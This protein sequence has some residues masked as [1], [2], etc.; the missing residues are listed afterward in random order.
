MRTKGN[1]IYD[2]GKDMVGRVASVEDTYGDEGS[3][4][5]FFYCAKASPSDR[6]KYNNH[7]TVKSTAL[8]EYLIKLVKQP[9]VNLILDPFAGSGSTLVAAEQLGLD[10]VGI[11]MNEEYIEIIKK[12]LGE[13]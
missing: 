4:A 5:R 2:T 9:E 10:S 3:T 13:N 12:R 8:M 11:E 7:P 6:G 1:H